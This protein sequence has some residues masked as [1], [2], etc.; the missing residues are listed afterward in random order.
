MTRGH[1]DD[2]NR[3]LRE[4]VVVTEDNDTFHLRR[5]WLGAL[6]AATALAGDV[7]DAVVWLRRAD[8]AG[9]GTNRLFEPWLQ[10][11]RAY[12]S[13]GC[14]AVTDAVE[15]LSD[16]ARSARQRHQPTVE[17]A[18]LFDI[19][20]YNGTTDHDRFIEVADRIGTNL[21]AALATAARGYATDDGELLHSAAMRL[22]ALDHDLLA[23]EA[24]T[25]AARSY[26]RGGCR[27]AAAACGEQAAE[28]RHR[29]NGARTPLAAPD[30]IH[31]L[32]TQ[33]EREIAL[34]ATRY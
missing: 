18:A 20:R 30:D 31:A 27:A 7:D 34:L 29:C 10:T 12:V 2:A 21:S 13:A 32:L 4:A 19:L 11:W 24:M 5:C 23:A 26:R 3:W 6:A 1:L 14:G 15:T 16:V 8:D 22:T 17:A 28:L 25:C 9:D 33:R